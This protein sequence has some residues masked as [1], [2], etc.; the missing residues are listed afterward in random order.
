MCSTAD[1]K[2]HG[3]A[4]QQITQIHIFYILHSFLE[5]KIIRT[6]DTLQLKA[7]IAVAESES[8]SLAAENL[9]LTQPA[10][11][12]R[13]ASLEESLGS[14]LLDRMGRNLRLT[15]AGK[16]LLPRARRILND[17]QD[18]QRSIDNLSGTVQGDLRIATSHHIGLHRLPAILRNFLNRHPDVNL[19]LEFVDSDTAYEAIHRGQVE[20]AII[21]LAQGEPQGISTKALWHDTLE[22][23][24][25]PNH[26]LA[27]FKEPDLKTLCQYPAILPEATTETTRLIKELMHQQGL[28]FKQA[29][30]TNYLETIKMMVSVGLG[31]SALPHSMIDEQ[32]ATLSFRDVRLE[33]SLGC[34]TLENRS[35]SNAANAF[36]K[37]LDHQ[38]TAT[39]K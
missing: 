5:S 35:L 37:E 20:L 13:V 16:T 1:S 6:M 24:V 9:H 30:P 23:V 22:F 26:P 33:R 4:R 21:T 25:A 2:L 3:I 39:H 12:K 31:W 7:F 29:L 36:L 11:S 8:F 38:G 19:Q 15:E 18:A 32:L 28:S 27:Q 34:I 10:V 14:K 17:I